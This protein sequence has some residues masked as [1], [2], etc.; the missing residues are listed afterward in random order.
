MAEDQV[1]TR[2]SA[3]SIKT[4]KI[5]IPFLTNYAD[6][7]YFFNYPLSVNTLTSKEVLDLSV[8]SILQYG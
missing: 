4:L 7:H 8:T 6:S 5:T 3:P 1:K 2:K